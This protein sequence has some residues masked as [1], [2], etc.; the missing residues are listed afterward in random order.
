M[1]WFLYDNGLRHK[2]VNDLIGNNSSEIRDGILDS[3]IFKLTFVSGQSLSK[4][5]WLILQKYQSLLNQSLKRNSAHMSSLYLTPKLSFEP[6]FRM[7]IMSGYYT[8]NKRL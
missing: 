1:D 5:S 3:Y 4:P 8:K 6:R 2:R 7:L